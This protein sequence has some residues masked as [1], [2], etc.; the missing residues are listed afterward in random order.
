M[1]V[2]LSIETSSKICS[3]ALHEDGKLRAYE[4]VVQERSHSEQITVLIGKVL[5]SVPAVNLSAIAV[6]MGPGSYTGLRIG[7][8]TA[9][10]L[11]YALGLPLLAVNTLQIIAARTNAEGNP[12]KYM[13]C[14]MIDA[15]RMEVYTAR[16]NHENNFIDETQ[17]MILDEHSFAD[18]LKSQ[19]IIFSGDGSGKLKNLL[20]AQS[21]ALFADDMLPSAKFMG[22][23]AYQLFTEGRFEDVAYFEPFYLK[24]FYTK[25]S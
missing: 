18:L 9:K 5:E 24:E 1:S 8:S 6:S 20:G 16:F 17:A 19:K 15:R 14:P 7:V 13:V 12:E 10:G 3:V 23:L 21:N 25:P 11:C 4:E 2:I 22:A